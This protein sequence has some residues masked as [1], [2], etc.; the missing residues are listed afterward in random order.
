MNV[1][2]ICDLCGVAPIGL[3]PYEPLAVTGDAVMVWRNAALNIC[4]A[5][6]NTAS[7]IEG[8]SVNAIS[9]DGKTNFSKLM[10]KYSRRND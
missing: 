4:R 5:L 1:D 8:E 6:I 3:I 2:D 9:F 7:R 10:K